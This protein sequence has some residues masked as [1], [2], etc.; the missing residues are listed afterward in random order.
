MAKKDI[1]QIASMTADEAKAQAVLLLSQRV[2]PE[3]LTELSDEEIKLI[4]IIETVGEY[5]E[6]DV[7]LTFAE[8]IKLNRVSLNR[9]GVKEIIQV[10]VAGLDEKMKRSITDILRRD[11][12]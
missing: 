7:L 11:K 12:K 5:A 8:K 6:N 3:L 9:Q 4:A 10:A 1:D 2:R